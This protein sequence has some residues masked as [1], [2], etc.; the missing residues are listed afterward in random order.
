MRVSSQTVNQFESTNNSNVVNIN[1]ANSYAGT[2][3]PAHNV[4]HAD[5]RQNQI[6]ATLTDAELNSFVADLELVH[7]SR[8]QIL[9]ESNAIPNYM[10]FPTAAI[11]SL[12]YLTDMGSSSELAVVGNDGV[13]GISL[14]MSDSKAIHQAKVCG[15]GYCYRLPAH[16]VKNMASNCHG[17]L[18]TLLNY[19]QNMYVQAS[20]TAVCNRHHSVDQQLSR[21][22]LKSLDRVDCNVIMMTQE[23]IANMLGVRRETVTEAALKLL[24]EGAIKYNR[25]HITVLNRQLLEKRSCECYLI[26]QQRK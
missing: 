26:D 2:T 22:L 12:Q 16:L 15:E 20:Q 1:Q 3:V 10:Y 4:S 24:N 7:L 17:M 14:L 5:P 11:V 13:V 23:T 6:L 18:L 21:R 9:C 25:G 8:N 19:S